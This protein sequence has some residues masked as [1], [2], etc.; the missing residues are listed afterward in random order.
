M[1]ILKFNE[2]QS[3][4]KFVKITFSG[5]DMV[6]LEDVENTDAYRN[7]MENNNYNDSYKDRRENAIWFGVE[8]LINERGLGGFGTEIVDSNGNIID[9]EEIFD[10]ANKYNV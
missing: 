2:S 1:K 3:N 9:D 8:E 4:E 7:N 10:A 5:E 6:L